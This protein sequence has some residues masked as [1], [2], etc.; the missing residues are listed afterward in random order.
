MNSALMDFIR[1][2]KQAV[3]AM[4]KA[5][6]FALFAVLTLGIGIGASTTVFTI[7]NTLLLNPLPVREPSQASGYL[8]RPITD[9]ASGACSAS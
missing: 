7:V 8:H 1:D 3:R 5:P 9:G 4:R 2:S 6:L